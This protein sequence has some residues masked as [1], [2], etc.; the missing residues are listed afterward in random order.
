MAP[1]DVV[2]E[3][4]REI[5]QGTE[6][7]GVSKYTMR[8]FRLLVGVDKYGW[9]PTEASLCNPHPRAVRDIDWQVNAVL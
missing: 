2:M 5:V 6:S 8:L 4:F 3:R 1:A 9:H 7:G